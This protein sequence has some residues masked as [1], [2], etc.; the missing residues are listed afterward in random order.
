MVD[1]CLSK[2][3]YW[4]QKYIGHAVLKFT[5]KVEVALGDF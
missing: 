4:I 5:S 3:T 2:F 1:K